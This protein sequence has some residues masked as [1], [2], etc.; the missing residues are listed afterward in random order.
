MPSPHRHLFA[1]LAA[2]AV[3]LPSCSCQPV[4]DEPVRKK[5]EE[6]AWY[7][8]CIDID[9]SRLDNAGTLPMY[10][11]TDGY[12]FGQQPVAYGSMQASKD[13]LWSITVKFSEP[14]VAFS[15]RSGMHE[16]DVFTL[17]GKMSQDGRKICAQGA[18]PAQVMTG[19]ATEAWIQ[20]ISDTKYRVQA[21]TREKVLP[22]VYVFDRTPVQARAVTIPLL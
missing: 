21:A 22:Y 14:V 12:A 16:Y 6:R 10:R 13:G 3:L 17:A 7:L 15:G 9:K 11:R 1:A 4:A 5:T 18:L 19:I 8:T 20:K 2:A